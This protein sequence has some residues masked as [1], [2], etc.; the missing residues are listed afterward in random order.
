MDRCYCKIIK[1]LNKLE[2]ELQ[3]NSQDDTTLAQEVQEI[4]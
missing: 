3:H 1:K 2:K 4:R